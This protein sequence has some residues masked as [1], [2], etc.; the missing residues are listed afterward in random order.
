MALMLPLVGAWVLAAV[1][2]VFDGR[3]RWVAGSALLGLLGVFAASVALLP[4][5]LT[6]PAPELVAGGW[7]VGMGIRLRA[8]PL[9]VV[10]C[11]VT[12]GVLLV[13]Y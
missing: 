1:L 11:V 10:F 4:A 6:G 3:R 9:S 2:S 12:D 8:D 5:A 13:A 7:P